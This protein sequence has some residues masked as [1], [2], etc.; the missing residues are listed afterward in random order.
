MKDQIASG[1]WW[2]VSCFNQVK[3]APYINKSFFLSGSPQLSTESSEIEYGRLSGIAH[4]ELPWF[5]SKFGKLPSFKINCIEDFWT[6]IQAI[7]QEQVPYMHEVGLISWIP[8]YLLDYMHSLL[9]THGKETLRELM[10]NLSMIV[11]WW[12]NPAPYKLKLL[13]ALW[14]DDIYGV[15]TFPASEWFFAFQD[16]NYSLR[17]NH[18]WLL[19]ITNTGIFYEFVSTDEMQGGKVN[20][21][22]TIYDLSQVKEWVNYA[23]II[24]TNAWLWRYNLWDTVKFSSLSPFRIKVTWR[25]KHYISAFGEHVIQEEIQAL[26]QIAIDHGLHAIEYTVAPHMGETATENHHERFIEY[27]QP[28]YQQEKNSHR[29]LHLWINHYKRRM[30]I[31]MTSGRHE[32]YNCWKLVSSKN[33]LLDY[34]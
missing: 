2:I 8:P 20:A 16:N 1:K 34:I 30:N 28:Q 18:N 17:E 33:D 6:K 3:H 31:I 15:E 5:I 23:M 7:V 13:E 26:Q 9:E 4:K 19:L 14:D 25:T 12:V 27:D 11:Y 22:A 21:N 24:S 32:H 29:F 10:P